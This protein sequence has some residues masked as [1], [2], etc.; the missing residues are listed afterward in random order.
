MII[1]R[2]IVCIYLQYFLNNNNNNN[3]MCE[4]KF[5]YIINKLQILN[6]NFPKI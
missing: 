6:E 3:F 4:F 5:I 1:L 2:F